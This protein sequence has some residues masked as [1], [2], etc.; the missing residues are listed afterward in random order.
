MYMLFYSLFTI[1]L[2]LYTNSYLYKTEN[3]YNSHKFM[4]SSGVDDV[5]TPGPR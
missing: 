1:Y 5:C 4:Y 2:Q 3:I